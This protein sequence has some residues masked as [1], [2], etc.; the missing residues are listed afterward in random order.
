MSVWDGFVWG[1]VIFIFTITAVAVSTG[2]VA[3]SNAIAVGN[4]FTGQ[5][6]HNYNY[7]IGF[8][9]QMDY[10]FVFLFLGGNI[11]ILVRAA[12]LKTDW[13]DYVL[14]WFASFIIVYLSFW[15]SNVFTAVFSTYALASGVGWF[16]NSIYILR[17]FPVYEAIFL[18]MYSIV[19]LLALNGN[20]TLPLNDGRLPWDRG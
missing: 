3:T 6:L 18:G 4:I 8:I 16:A 15:M 20:V 5:A 2:V 14:A 9:P 1:V 11:A 19:I 10:V 7:V 12:Y 13:S 17:F